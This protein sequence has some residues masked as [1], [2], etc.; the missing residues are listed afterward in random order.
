[1][2]GFFRPQAPEIYEQTTGLAIDAELGER[3]VV[4][5]AGDDQ[6]IFELLRYPPAF[7]LSPLLD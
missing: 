5:L 6:N 4:A 3:R 2:A 1:M 7:N